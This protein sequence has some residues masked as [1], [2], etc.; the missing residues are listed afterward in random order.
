MFRDNLRYAAITWGKSIVAAIMCLFV[1]VSIQFIAIT[2]FTK[3]IGYTVYEVVDAKRG[4]AIYTHYYADG[5]DQ[6]IKEYAQ[7]KVETVI[8]RSELTV[9]Q[10]YTAQTISQILSLIIFAATLYQRVW[11]IGIS[12]NN[13]VKFD[14]AKQDKLR[15]FKIGCLATV[16]SVLVYILL[17]LGRF[18]V[19]PNLIFAIY[20]M[21]NIHIFG[22]INMLFGIGT[23]LFNV[24]IYKL[25]L[26]AVPLLILPA[27]CAISYLLGYKDI[28]ISE[29]IIYKRKRG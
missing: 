23:Q 8:E 17:L 12:D 7:D 2:I 20:K 14:R 16:P 6:K 9:K 11:S 26:A 15:G 10:N 18:G 13:K 4:D 28:S 27:V 3:E 1:Y 25:A 19:A 29:K 24:P 5:E 22:Y 21:F